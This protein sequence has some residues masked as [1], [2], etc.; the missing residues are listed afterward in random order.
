MML[1][2]E[3]CAMGVRE[4]STLVG[5]QATSHAPMKVS[6]CGCVLAVAVVGE[7]LVF[8]AIRDA[9]GC[10]ARLFGRHCAPWSDFGRLEGHLGGPPLQRRGR[11]DE[12][13]WVCTSADVRNSSCGLSY[14]DC[15]VIGPH[16]Q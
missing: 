16:S 1:A 11:R 2:T 9:P 6:N 15:V 8:W 3:E 10:W 5:G 14:L 7:G 13:P 4:V 12:A